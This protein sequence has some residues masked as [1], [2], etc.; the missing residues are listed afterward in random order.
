M[1][2]FYGESTT[3]FQDLGHGVFAD[4]TAALGLAAPSRSK[5]GF[6]IAFLDANNDG[7]L[8][9]LTA[10]GHVTDYRPEFAYTMP[11]QLL[12]GDGRRRL[13]DISDRAG[14]PF[15]ALHLGRGLA[16][17][18]LDNDGRT[19]ALLVAA[20]EPLV[21]LHNVTDGGH[22]LTVR[23]EGTASNRD[24]V[25][26][27]VTVTAFGRRQVITRFGGGS[28]LSA[29]DP[30]IHVGLGRAGRAELVEVAWPSG[31]IDRHRDL[32]AD[33]AYLLREG[34]T[35]ARPLSGW[36]ISWR[37]DQKPVFLE[38]NGFP[39]LVW[40]SHPSSLWYS[41]GETPITLRNWRLK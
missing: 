2:N 3:F 35:T 37:L 10:N 11:A 31:R 38:E 33:R 5:L 19:D 20:D 17:G 39:T 15:Q 9:L 40:R 14:P 22:S 34:E 7:R 26:A 8:D 27:R 41:L 1:T 12:I 28:Y 32:I 16:I 30:R 6:G 23:L 36:D 29:A 13:T 25:G 4:R 24:A 18:D 21:L